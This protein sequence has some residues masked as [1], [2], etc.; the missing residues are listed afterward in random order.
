MKHDIKEC[1]FEFEVVDRTRGKERE[2]K[3]L[4]VSLKTKG[5]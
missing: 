2:Q 5:I 3:T 1:A 4:K